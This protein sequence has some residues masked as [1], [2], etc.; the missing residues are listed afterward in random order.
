MVRSGTA[1]YANHP[2]LNPAT[3]RFARALLKSTAGARQNKKAARV[4][5][6]R[7]RK[8][9]NAGFLGE[10]CSTDEEQCKAL[11]AQLWAT[12]RVT[13]TG[14]WMT[15]CQGVQPPAFLNGAVKTR[16]RTP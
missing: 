6:E 11:F 16:D 15:F 8:I 12:A 13:R 10:R 7:D 14:A 1:P 3:A 5:K 2:L 9:Q 4:C